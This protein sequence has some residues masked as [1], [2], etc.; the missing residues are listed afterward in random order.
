MTVE[1]IKKALTTVAGIITASGV[2]VGATI[3]LDN[4]Y[5]KPS[6][7]KAVKVDVLVKLDEMHKTILENEQ[8]RIQLGNNIQATKVLL[9]RNRQELEDVKARLAMQQR[10]QQIMLKAM[11]APA[12][13]P[14]K[15]E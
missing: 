8:L 1:Q 15:T 4:R 6:D 2:I 13:E 11:P 7:L 9:E 12:V 5:V 14:A 3:A 10:Q